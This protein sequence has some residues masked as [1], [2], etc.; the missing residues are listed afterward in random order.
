MEGGGGGVSRGAWGP[1]ARAITLTIHVRF[2]GGGHSAARYLAWGARFFFA[3]TGDE[4]DDDDD[5]ER[6]ERRAEAK[7]KLRE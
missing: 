3:R 2:L 7:K 6:A 1:G 4:R 5:F